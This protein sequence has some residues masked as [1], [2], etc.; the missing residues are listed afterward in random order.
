MKAIVIGS[1]MSGLTAA[2]YLIKAGHEVTVY[3]QDNHLGGVTA[4]IEQKGFRWDM[5]PLLLEKFGI[6]EPAYNILFDLGIENQVEIV[7]ADRSLSFPDFLL[8][9]PDQYPG[10]DWRKE[11]LKALFPADA[12]G[13]D[14]YYSFYETMMDLVA[15][16]DRGNSIFVKLWML[17]LFQKVKRMSKWTAKE[18]TEHFFSDPKL[19]AVFTGIL[20]DFCV[21]P[22]EFPGLGVPLCNVETA[23]DLRIPQTGSKAGPRPG[24]SYIKGGIGNLANAMAEYIQNNGGTITTNAPVEKVLVDQEKVSGI[25]LKNGEEISADIVVA[26]GGAKELF[27]TLVGDEYLKDEFKQSLDALI[28]MESVLMV[29]LGIDIDPLKYQ[30]SSLCYY[31]E[32]YDIEGAVHRCRDGEFTADDGFLVYI[33]TAHSPEM[34]PNGEHAVTIYTIAPNNLAEGT[35]EEKKQFFVDKLI[36]KA[37]QIIPGLEGHIKHKVTMTPEDFKKITHLSYHAFGGMAPVMG[38]TNPAHVTPIKGLYFIGAQ[39]ES[40]GCVPAVMLGAKKAVE[41]IIKS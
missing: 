15:L 2:A 7:R 41:G 26:S 1:G 40:G 30:K 29:H 37:A 21:L 8:E 39:S 3:E 10:A 12:D 34:A 36:K 38:Q 22:S 17:G 32:T 18:V 31:Y 20:A 25:R 9:K 4:T 28:P 19:R 6:G 33:P 16:S 27:H 23:Y 14:R 24:S 35:W 5:G 11:Q 13:L